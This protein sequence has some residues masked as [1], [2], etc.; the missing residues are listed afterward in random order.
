[1]KIRFRDLTPTQKTIIC[2]GCGG[3]GGVLNPPDFL[4][5]ASCDHHDFNYWLGFTE[6]HR[7]KADVQFYEAMLIDANN[8]PWYKR[9]WL[10]I[11]ARTYYCAVR[12]FGAK[13]FYYADKERTLEDLLK[14]VEEHEKKNNYF[15]P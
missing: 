12:K 7:E 2:N 4:F 8:G 13:N 10:R 11:M 9:W 5:V 15:Y 3:K 14:I 6:K 1:M